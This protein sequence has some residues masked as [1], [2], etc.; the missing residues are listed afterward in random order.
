MIMCVYSYFVV[1]QTGAHYDTS[2]WQ[3]DVL[4]LGV[5]GICPPPLPPVIIIE[6]TIITVVEA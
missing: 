6:D 1:L 3:L 5:C 2:M 4:S